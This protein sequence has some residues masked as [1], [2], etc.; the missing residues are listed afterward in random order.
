MPIALLS[1][2]LLV[3]KPERVKMAGD[4]AKAAC[5][6]AY[7]YKREQSPTGVKVMEIEVGQK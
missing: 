4:V 6:L 5:I 7:R 3:D 1:A 2:H